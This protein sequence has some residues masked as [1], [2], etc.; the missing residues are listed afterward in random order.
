MTAT[1]PEKRVL[2]LLEANAGVAA[3]VGT[4][5]YTPNFPAAP[6]LPGIIFFV[7]TGNSLSTIGLRNVSIQTHCYESRS[8]LARTLHEAVRT[9]FLGDFTDQAAHQALLR[10]FDIS[11]IEEEQEGQ[12]LPFDPDG[13]DKGTPVMLGFWTVW[14]L[15]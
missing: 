4:D 8:L 5:V 3:I 9:A 15:D 10:T 7:Q 12:V 14:F 1:P 6:T 2:D 11:L 13:P